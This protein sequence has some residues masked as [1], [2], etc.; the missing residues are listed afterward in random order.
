MNNSPSNNSL[1]LRRR[2]K[3]ALPEGSGA[4]L[5]LNY[6]ASV[7]RNL[8]PLGFTLSEPLI[9]ACQGLSLEALTELYRQLAALRAAKGAHRAFRPMYP[10]FPQQVMEMA[11]GEL[12]LNAIVHYVTGGKWLPPSR[13]RLRLPLGDKPR[14]QVIELGTREDFEGI[15]TQITASNAALSEQDR[16]DLTWFVSAYGEGIERLLPELI[17][18]KEN[19]AFLAGL[20]IAHTTQAE[21]FLGRYC[22][23]ATD[24]LRLAVALSGGDVS[25]AKPTKF[26]SFSRPER[27]LLLRLLEGRQNPTEDMLRWRERW[28]RL[29]ERLHPGEQRAAFPKSA[30]AFT[31]LRDGLPFETFNSRMEKALAAGDTEETAR[32]LGT[33]AGDFARRLD[34]VLRLDPPAQNG[35]VAAFASVADR[36]STPVLLQVRSHFQARAAQ[37]PLRVFFPKGNVA[38]AHVEENHLPHIPES[39]CTLVADACAEALGR[40]FS[41][42]APLGKVY[43]DP[44]LS[45]YTVPFATRSASKSFRTVGRGSYLPL[46]A[47]CQVLRFFVWWRNGKERTD[48]DLSAAMFGEDFVLK[49]LISYYSLKGYGGVHSGDIVDAPKGAS[50]FIDV[51]L[52]KVRE[53]GVRYVVMVLQSYTQQPYA[54]LPECFAGWMA[55]REPGSGEV[56]DPRTVEAR[57]DLTADT[58]VAIPLIFDVFEGKVV[59]CDMALRSHPNWNNNVHGNLSG[60]A[61]TLQSM[62]SLKKP[63]L[64]DL[65]LL[66]AEARGETVKSPEGADAVFSVESGTPFRQEEIASQYLV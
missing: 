23:T 49:D 42:L 53:R 24:V 4:D 65:F 7:A 13:P 52:S 38:K 20:L 6:P 39:V 36:V 48:I 21:A 16:E 51:T 8:E 30:A 60:I 64:Y 40:R 17:P 34:H 15:F 58:R 1:Y 59:W 56:Y 14:P 32:I 29:G 10:D 33:R 63:N 66:H 28:V 25:L 35:V 50:E 27:R 62:V 54:E 12:Y 11:E 26:R 47:G 31:I 44:K 9:R 19:V 18:Q 5:P 37:P 55:R 45:D 57:L 61:V 41:A 43:V 22:K 2:S 3:V 46:P